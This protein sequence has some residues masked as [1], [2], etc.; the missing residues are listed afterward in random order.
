MEV[1]NSTKINVFFILGFLPWVIN[2]QGVI[3]KDVGMASALLLASGI[4]SKNKNSIFEI[5]IIFLLLLYAFMVRVNS[6]VAVAPLLWYLI[7]KI[8]SKPKLSFIYCLFII[9]FKLLFLNYFNY[10]FF[11]CKE[12]QYANLYYDR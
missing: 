6:I 4:L 8:S 9:I 1:K 2:F 10:S 12:R 11:K 5:I 3:W 7:Y